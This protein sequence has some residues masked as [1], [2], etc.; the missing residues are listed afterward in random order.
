MLNTQNYPSNKETFLQ[1]GYI[2]KHYHVIKR[3]L[4]RDFWPLFLWSEPIWSPVQ[5]DKIFLNSFSI[6]PRF[7]IIKFENSDSLV[8]KWHSRVKSFLHKEKDFIWWSLYRHPVFDFDKFL[9]LKLFLLVSTVWTAPRSLKNYFQILILHSALPCT[10]TPRSILVNLKKDSGG[11]NDTME[12]FEKFYLLSPRI[13]RQNL[14][15]VGKYFNLF[16]R[17][18][19]G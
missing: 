15:R 3:S 5:G 2:K 10:Y 4:S 6:L 19:A 11:G 14:N 17:G 9:L 12:F 16:V 7:S 1:T 18:P 13:S 8:W